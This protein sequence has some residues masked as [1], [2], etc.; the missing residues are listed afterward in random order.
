MG[1]GLPRFRPTGEGAGRNTRGRVCSP[2][3]VQQYQ[4]CA[5]RDSMPTRAVGVAGGSDASG[6]TGIWLVP[7]QAAALFGSLLRRTFLAAARL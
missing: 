4:R 2:S 7:A 3:F 5:L 6:L 1:L